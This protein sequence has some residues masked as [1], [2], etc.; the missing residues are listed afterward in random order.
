MTWRVLPSLFP[1][2][3]YLKP[4]VPFLMLQQSLCSCH[5]IVWCWVPCGL[6]WAIGWVLLVPLSLSECVTLAEVWHWNISPNSGQL[7]QNRAVYCWFDLC[8]LFSLCIHGSSLCGF[9]LTAW[10]SRVIVVEN[11]FSVSTR[12]KPAENIKVWG[13]K[14]NPKWVQKVPWVVAEPKHKDQSDSLQLG[15]VIRQ[16]LVWTREL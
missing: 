13:K 14:I 3:Q 10:C 12:T 9:L 6:R 11:L 8:Q 15:R 4:H 16:D 1:L 7:V 2:I 5:R